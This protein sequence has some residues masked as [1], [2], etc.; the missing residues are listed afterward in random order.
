MR[1]RAKIIWGS[2]VGAIAL[3]VTAFWFT[4]DLVRR[5]DDN[6][7]TML[8]NADSAPGALPAP[9]A[10]R[11]WVIKL[12]RDATGRTLEIEGAFD[13][14]VLPLPGVLIGRAS[15]SNA[16]GFGDAPFATIEGMEVRVGSMSPFDKRVVI[17]RSAL[18]G[19]KLN[20]ERNAAG[21]VNWATATSAQATAASGAP[22][23]QPM[24]PSASTDQ[25]DGW[26]TSV[27][28]I[29][30]TDAAV[31]WHDAMTGSSWR[32]SD[33]ELLASEIQPDA[34]FPMTISFAFERDAAA[35]AVDSAMRAFTTEDR[36]RLDDLS[37]NFTGVDPGDLRSLFGSAV[38]TGSPE[39]V[40]RAGASSTLAFS[41]MGTFDD[42]TQ[43]L[44]FSGEVR[45]AD[46][47]VVP[48]TIGGTLA[49]P[50][51]MLGP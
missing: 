50:D 27:E 19:L 32:L 42:S 44:E 25:N 35:F 4:S 37:V 8:A 47:A 14:Y 43:Q 39:L 48:A 11:D 21:E 49:A 2:I 16:D 5:S 36:L 24:A 38:V 29:E 7:E 30:I 40:A 12:V 10:E 46:G 9:S 17:E 31:S 22:T 45:L 18:A 20:L 13:A 26:S 28:A 15:L 51:I 1:R 6:L 34:D 41:G 33:V 23:E 3:A